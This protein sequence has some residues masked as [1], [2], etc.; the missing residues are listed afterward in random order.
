MFGVERVGLI[1]YAVERDVCEIVT[2]DSLIEGQGI[3]SLLLNTLEQK[4]DQLGCTRLWLVTTND[5]HKAQ[6]FYRKHGFRVVGID[7]GAVA[8]ARKTKPSIPHF[9]LDGVPIEHEIQMERPLQSASERREEP[10]D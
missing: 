3:G 8:E 4:A 9:G 2:L 1:T 7:H 10:S 6:A 5:N